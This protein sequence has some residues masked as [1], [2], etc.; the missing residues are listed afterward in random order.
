MT[1]ANAC[2]DAETLA[3]WYD[4]TLTAAEQRELESH[5]STCD[6]CQAIV[7]TLARFDVPVQP[8]A[9]ERMWRSWRWVVP[10][11]AAAALVL[12]AS[13]GQVGRSGREG[14]VGQESR[15]GQE[16]QV[17]RV[18]PTERKRLE[19]EVPQGSPGARARNAPPPARKAETPPANEQRAPASEVRVPSEPPSRDAKSTNA[20]AAAP[21]AAAPPP[22]D[23][24]AR[25]LQMTANMM[26]RRDIVVSPDRSMLWRIRG[27]S[28]ERSTDGG[29]TWSPQA[30]GATAPLS[31]GSS[32]AATVCWIV[33]RSGTVLRTTDGRTWQVVPFPEPIDLTDVEASNAD[34]AA[35]TTADA[36]R[37]TTADGGRTWTEQ[38]LQEF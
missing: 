36:R 8:S 16:G 27:L 3:A 15:V 38:R 20:D 29:T 1:H 22:V 24:A 13:V 23:A 33:G 32:P 6:R 30:T 4:Q 11:A 37:F 28:V 26:V 21:P 19:I 12:W 2:P 10:T 31:A 17:A 9:R 14:R 5:V 7:A 35:V 34:A 25:S 18:E